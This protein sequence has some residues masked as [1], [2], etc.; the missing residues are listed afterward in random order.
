MHQEQKEV[1]KEIEVHKIPAWEPYGIYKSLAGK[2]KSEGIN[3][4][5]LSEK[6]GNGFIE[7]LSKWVRGNLFIPDA[8]KFWIK[9][10]I[11]YLKKYLNQHKI[12]AV[13]SSG[14]PHSAHLIA[15]KLKVNLIF[16]GFQILEILGP[17]LIFIKN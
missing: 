9:P 5:F 8:R 12:D 15:L 1:P 7:N 14:P 16:F 11:K 10:S 17:I 13:I 6:K 4:G 3:S 2:K